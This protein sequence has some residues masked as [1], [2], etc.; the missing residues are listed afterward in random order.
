MQEKDA[1]MGVRTEMINCNFGD[2]RENFIFANSAKR[3]VCQVK[4]SQPG[5]D[6]GLPTSVNDIVIW[7]FREGF[8]FTKINP[9]KKFRIYSRCP[10]VSLFATT[11]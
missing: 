2:F 6:L 3:H 11:Q 8:S 5:H 1:T 9:R 10:S 4:K 7:P